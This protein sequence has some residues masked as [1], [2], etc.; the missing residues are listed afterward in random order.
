MAKILTFEI[1]EN[2]YQDFTAFLK[3]CSMEIHKSLEIMNQDQA[4]IDRLRRESEKIRR[5]TETVKS[6]TKIYLEDLEKRVLKTE[7]NDVEGNS[8]VWQRFDS[9]NQRNSAK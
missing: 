4:E 2:E 5:H 1:P 8:S 9:F 7:Q 3:D 6:E